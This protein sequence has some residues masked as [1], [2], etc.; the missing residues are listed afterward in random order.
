MEQR[1]R[2]QRQS[3]RNGAAPEFVEP[4]CAQIVRMNPKNPGGLG[5]AG[6]V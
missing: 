5:K 6:R 4:P 1:G 2:K 3:H